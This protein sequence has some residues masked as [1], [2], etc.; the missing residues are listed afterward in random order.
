MTLAHRLS[1]FNRRRKW[2]LFLDEL[3]PTESTSVLDV[4]YCEKEFSPVDNFIEKHYPHPRRLTALGVAAGG[5]F[6]RRYPEVRVI[7][8]DGVRFP[9]ADKEFDIC[10]S[11]AVLEHVGGAER[12][13][14]FLSEVVRVSRRAFITTPNRYFPIELHTRTPLLHFLLPKRTFDAYLARVGQGWAAGDYMTLLSERALRGLLSDA[15][16]RKYRLFRNRLC[17]FTADFAVVI[18]CDTAAH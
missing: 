2:Q 11:N 16:V 5:D 6:A 13:R 14:Q 7:H 1:S 9:F 18:D 17:G 12:Q 10:W 15:G 8:Y 3:G 4:G